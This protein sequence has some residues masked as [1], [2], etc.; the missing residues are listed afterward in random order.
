MKKY[1]KLILAGI[2]AA[3]LLN[4]CA[5]K[6]EV[7]K[8]FVYPTGLKFDK[9]R[10]NKVP[11]KAQLVKRSYEK[12]PS[13][14][15]LTDYTPPVGDQGAFG[16]CVAWASTYA[17]MTTA[18]AVVSQQKEKYTLEAQAFSPY[19]LYRSCNPDQIKKATGMYCEDALDWLKDNGVPRRSIN[20]MRSDYA[21]FSMD[22]YKTSDLFTIE[23]YSRIHEAEDFN[24]NEMSETEMW[25]VIRSIKKSLSEKKP[26]L[27]SFLVTSEFQM[28]K[29]VSDYIPKDIDYD[30]ANYKIDKGFGAHAMLIVGYDDNYYRIDGENYGAFLIQNSWGTEW[31]D[32]GC[33][34][35]NYEIACT[36][37]LGAYE[38]SNKISKVPT[39]DDEV[40]IVD[41]DEEYTDYY[42]YYDRYDPEKD[43]YDWF[44]NFYND[45]WWTKQTDNHEEEP[46][47]NHDK[48]DPKVIPVIPEPEKFYCIF[49][50]EFNL[51]IYNEEG[52]ITVRLN[53]NLYET[54]Q[55]YDSFTRFQLYMTN[56]RPCYVYAF[57]SD[58]SLQRP[59]KLFPPDDVNALLDYH[60]NTVVYPSEDSCMRLDSHV[61][62]DYLV[63]LYSLK[64]LKLEEIM[65]A[66][67]LEMKKNP[68]DV[69]QAV[70]NA[71]GK[72]KIVPV[73]NQA[74]DNDSIRF[75]AQVSTVS[76]ASIMR[77]V[78]KIKHD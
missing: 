17:G 19:Y 14:V 65:S 68:D 55:S 60:E 74:F 61:G 54:S 43:L 7:Q 2:L 39:E 66:Y 28:L 53:N 4:L 16:T 35:V 38:I 71:C 50:G 56:K 63:V 30:F 12:L 69:Y 23:S 75:A 67:N 77:I 37:M 1:G 51:P 49:E 27:G 18:E 31:G 57:A 40:I 9:K 45:D 62:T 29:G 42:D 25:S 41:E 11:K 48:K 70:V 76:K 10:Y 5:C 13:Y 26:V 21:S 46:D 33:I 15:V 34:W 73:N 47:Y 44:W 24:H 58:D 8:D 6:N 64:E 20:E 32:K 3:V 22:Y 36:Y 78:I 52:E 59:N 72:E